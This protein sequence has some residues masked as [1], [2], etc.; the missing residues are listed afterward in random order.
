[1]LCADASASAPVAGTAVHPGAAGTE[2]QRRIVA[3]VPA[4]SDRRKKH[5]ELTHLCNGDPDQQKHAPG[6]S[7]A[8]T[9][10]AAAAAVG[11]ACRVVAAGTRA[12]PA[13]QEGRGVLP[14]GPRWWGTPRIAASRGRVT[15]RA[16]ERQP[17]VAGGWGH[18][19]TRTQVPELRRWVS[20]RTAT[21]GGCTTTGCWNG[22]CGGNWM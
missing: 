12:P 10:A 9:V 2:A 5:R 11:R 17:S 14:W 21:V 3:S 15:A 6:R 19:H 8:G 16:G 18:A 7:A 20:P 1:V 4:K 22:R 13:Q